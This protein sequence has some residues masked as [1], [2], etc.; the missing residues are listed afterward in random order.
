MTFPSNDVICEHGTAMDVHCCNC[1]SGFLFDISICTCL[2]EETYLTLLELKVLY[3]LLKSQYISYE[4]VPAITL[5][6]KI[7]HILED[8]DMD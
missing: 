3:D 6:K 4:N 7:R 2:K 8:N 5:I 1:H